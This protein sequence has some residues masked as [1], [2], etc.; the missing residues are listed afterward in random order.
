[1]VDELSVP[2]SVV[3][4]YH[5]LSGYHTQVT[6]QEFSE[7][8]QTGSKLQR[9]CSAMTAERRKKT[10]NRL[11]FVEEKRRFSG[12]FRK[13]AA[14]IRVLREKATATGSSWQ[15]YADSRLCKVLVQ[16]LCKMFYPD[17]NHVSGPKLKVINS[18]KKVLFDPFSALV[19]YTLIRICISIQIE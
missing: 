16:K 4:N 12:F 2:W 18:K 3:V 13:L 8:L 11:H 10:R 6:I 19:I 15:S 7:D 9:S 17:V 5:L 14:D 1:M